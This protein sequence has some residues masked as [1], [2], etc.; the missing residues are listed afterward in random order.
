MNAYTASPLAHDA[1][2][3]VHVVRGHMLRGL[4]KGNSWQHN[5]L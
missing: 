4:L 2:V 3:S 5:V 1:G